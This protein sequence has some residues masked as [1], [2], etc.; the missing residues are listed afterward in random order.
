MDFSD[1]INILTRAE[2]LVKIKDIEPDGDREAEN[3]EKKGWWLL[4]KPAHHR[5]AVFSEACR[6][7][8]FCSSQISLQPHP[9][10]LFKFQLFQPQSESICL[11]PIQ[12]VKLFLF[13]IISPRSLTPH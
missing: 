1:L 12:R 7:R 9:L 13:V 2:V 11:T 5:K 10:K 4:H 6:V 8:V 3:L